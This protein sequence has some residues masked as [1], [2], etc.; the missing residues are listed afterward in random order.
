MSAI[1]RADI[2]S[3]IA[4]SIGEQLGAQG[5]RESAYA[6]DQLGLDGASVV[7]LSYALEVGRSIPHQLDRQRLA[8][9]AVAMTQIAVR[10]LHARRGD[11]QVADTDAALRA[12]RALLAAVLVTDRDPDLSVQ[13]VDEGPLVAVGDGTFLRGQLGFQVVHRAALTR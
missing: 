9:G 2:R 3:R 8:V 11:A 1:D 13:W 6:Y 10:Y 4:A 7:H 5:W 12:G